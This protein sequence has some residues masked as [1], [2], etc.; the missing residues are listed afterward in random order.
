MAPLRLAFGD[1]GW[2]EDVD[3]VSRLGYCT[4]TVMSQRESCD[5]HLADLGA[6]EFSRHGARA[7]SMAPLRLASAKTYV[8]PKISCIVKHRARARPIAILKR[9]RL[10]E[11]SS[12][13]SAHVLHHLKP[14][15]RGP[16]IK[17]MGCCFVPDA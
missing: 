14:K 12:I 11:K 6:R 1:G 5:V 3:G 17:N 10:M 4:I 9:A 7:W 8:V 2:A 15:L 16:L 13:L